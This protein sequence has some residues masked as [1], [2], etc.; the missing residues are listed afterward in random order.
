MATRAVIVDANGTIKSTG[1]KMAS[2]YAAYATQVL[3]AL[4]TLLETTG[5]KIE[6]AV[7]FVSCGEGLNEHFVPKAS[8][9]TH[10]RKCHGIRQAQVVNNTAFYYGSRRSSSTSSCQDAEIIDSKLI[11]GMEDT[12]NGCNA[13]IQSLVEPQEDKQD[14]NEENGVIAAIGRTE[15][16]AREFYQQVQAWKRIPRVFATMKDTEREL[17]AEASLRRWL[18]TELHRSGIRNSDELDDELVDYIVGLLNHPDFCQP[19]VLILELHEF[20]GKCVVDIV[21]ALWKFMIVEIGLQSV[22]KSNKAELRNET[23]VATSA[24][25]CVPTASPSR[26]RLQPTDTV[27]TVDYK[28]RRASYRKKVGTKTGPAAYRELIEKHMIELSQETGRELVHAGGFSTEVRGGDARS[29]F[30]AG[31]RRKVDWWNFTDALQVRNRSRRHYNPNGYHNKS[32]LKSRSRSRS[33]SSSN[34]HSRATQ[35]HQSGES[36]RKRDRRYRS[37]SRR[38]SPRHF[39]RQDSNYHNKRRRRRSHS[40]EADKTGNYRRYGR[41][42]HR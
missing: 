39:N 33:R 34:C 25:S 35:R 15:T 29:E 28:R 40:R 10:L 2:A 23:Q 26:I 5:I 36:P 19:D 6:P 17:V 13:E 20:L 31:C 16:S 32:Q 38:T 8:L 30:Q 1:S 21:L 37:R 7:N 11:N 9:E 14:V 18:T 3:N 4:E 41:S 12:H 22:F 42:H 24:A 27:T